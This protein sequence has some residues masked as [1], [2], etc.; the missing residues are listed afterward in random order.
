MDHFEFCIQRNI[1]KKNLAEAYSNLCKV[2]RM[3]PRM[4]NRFKTCENERLGDIQKVRSLKIPEFYHPPPPPSAQLARPCSFSFV[5]FCL[6]FHTVIIINRKNWRITIKLHFENL[7]IFF[8]KRTY[9]HARTPSPVRFYSLF[10]GFPLPSS[11]NVLFEWP[12][13]W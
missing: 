7:S 9:T 12:L 8:K 6:I 11:T 2:I 4:C 1:K 10:N 13:V 3:F 5:M